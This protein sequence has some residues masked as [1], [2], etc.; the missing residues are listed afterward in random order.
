M[1]GRV[2]RKTARQD[3]Q[4]VNAAKSRCKSQAGADALLLHDGFLPLAQVG[5][6]LTADSSLLRA[7]SGPVTVVKHTPSSRSG[8][9]AFPPALLS[10]KSEFR[11][12]A[13]V[14][15]KYISVRGIQISIAFKKTTTQQSPRTAL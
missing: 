15:G 13:P 12:S 9:A 1:R 5:R 3:T 7:R 8:I 4:G 14:P 11:R 2:F 6:R 10:Q